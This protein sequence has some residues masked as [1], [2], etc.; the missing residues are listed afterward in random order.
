MAKKINSIISIILVFL[1]AG[2]YFSQAQN[3]YAVTLNDYASTRINPE[4]VGSKIRDLY[5]SGKYSHNLILK[6]KPIVNG[7]QYYTIELRNLK[8]DSNYNLISSSGVNKIFVDSNWGLVNDPSII[9]KLLVIWKANILY[10]IYYKDIHPNNNI[11]KKENFLVTACEENKENRGNYIALKAVRDACAETSSILITGGTKGAT[12]ELLAKATEDVLS[13]PEKVINAYAQIYI[14]SLLS[15][16]E[17]YARGLDEFYWNL[18]KKK[19]V[20]I[21]DYNDACNYIDLTYKAAN[22]TNLIT[23]QMDV[24]GRSDASTDMTSY[25]KEY[26]KDVVKGAITLTTETDENWIKVKLSDYVDIVEEIEKYIEDGER[27]K[28]LE[29]FAKISKSFENFL[30]SKSKLDQLQQKEKTA[31]Y[32]D[33]YNYQL[34][35]GYIEPMTTENIFSCI[36]LTKNDILNKFGQYDVDEGDAEGCYGWVYKNLPI[37]FSFGGND[38]VVNLFAFEGANIN[39]AIVGMTFSEIKSILGEPITEKLVIGEGGYYKKYMSY[40]YNNMYTIEF[41][42]SA[43]SDGYFSEEPQT[44]YAYIS[45][46]TYIS[47]DNSQIITFPDKNLEKAIRNAVNKPTGALYKSDVE[48]ITELNLQ[49]K[50]IKDIRGIGSLSNL[51]KL[52]LL[53]ND[54]KDISP[55]SDLVN[56]R[57]LN[58]GNINHGYLNYNDIRD[59]T[60]LKSLSNLQ[61]LHAYCLSGLE[62]LE[63]LSSLENLKELSLLGDLKLRNIEPISNLKGLQYL[64]LGY[65]TIE[66]I[67][68]LKSLINLKELDLYRAIIDSNKLEEL[69]NSLPNCTMQTEFIKKSYN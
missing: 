61:V 51:S 10:D 48:K 45:K 36:G 53:N 27:M 24:D 12:K 58:I 13:D 6:D 16:Y 42:S 62:N 7:V 38:K 30:T 35:K 43:D 25:I 21:I 33:S 52:T 63:P 46:Y 5:S 8:L 34:L 22:I 26:F 49:D 60:P 68:P 40:S 55:L 29:S 54:I 44:L 65:D 19:Q 64:S 67:K 2:V 41:Y 11:N 31:N 1:F 14:S 18:E 15:E 57:Y 4:I 32:S 69:R 66:D 50:G 9:E 47:R 3:A 28:T 56:L 17:K 23:L 20:E 39:G 37:T 59:L